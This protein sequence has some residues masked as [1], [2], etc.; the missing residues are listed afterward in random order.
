MSGVNEG[1]ST[2]E[3]T[4]HL[5]WAQFVQ[6]QEADQLASE[7]VKVAAESARVERVKADIIEAAMQMLG[8]KGPLTAEQRD[9]LLEEQLHELDEPHARQLLDMHI[10]Q[11]R[12]AYEILDLPDLGGITASSL[13][14]GTINAMCVRDPGDQ[15]LHVFADTELIIFVQALSKLVV[16]SVFPTSIGQR[17]IPRVFTGLIKFD[18]LFFFKL[19]NFFGAVVFTGRARASVPWRAEPVTVAQAAILTWAMQ[20]FATAHELAHFSAGHLDITE[21]AVSSGGRDEM[22]AQQAQEVEADAL[23]VRACSVCIDPSIYPELQALAPYIF[24][25]G[26]ELLEAGQTVVSSGT[27]VVVSAHPPTPD[28]LKALKATIIAEADF[29]LMLARVFTLQHLDVL[30][31]EW[32]SYL[33]PHLRQMKASGRAPHLERRRRTRE[34]DRPEILGSVVR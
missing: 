31:A 21:I 19:T 25:K 3:E 33:L 2:G 17:I 18:Q 14:A 28:R 29:E 32:R 4:D 34:H 9:R 5:A 10:K 1:E 6:T 7:L 26:I 11:I 15:S 22:E 12:G 13:P 27:A 24:L 8:R 30:F 16:S 23:A 20:R